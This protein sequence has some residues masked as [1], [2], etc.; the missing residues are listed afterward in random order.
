MTVAVLDFEANARFEWKPRLRTFGADLDR[1]MIAQ[2]E[3]AI[4]SVADDSGTR[5]RQWGSTTS[6]RLRDLRVRPRGRG[7]STA[8]KYSAAINRLALP[9]L[10]LAHTTKANADP[11]HPFGSVFWSNGARLTI[12]VAADGDERIVSTK[13]VNAR[14]PFPP[15]AF[16][17]AWTHELGPTEVP[18]ASSSR[19]RRRSLADRALAAVYTLGWKTVREITKVSSSRE[20]TFVISRVVIH[21][22]VY[23]AVR[24]RSAKVR[25]LA[26]DSTSTSGTSFGPSSCVHAHSRELRERRPRVDL[27]RQIVR[28]SRPCDADREAGAVQPEHAAERVLR[29]RRWPWSCGRAT[30]LGAP[31]C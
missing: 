29:V 23:G 7:V 3:T 2:P 6:Y 10:S 17:W 30:G 4:W 28:V 19:A 5:W 12:G 11:K 9:V 20:Q 26:P 24:A 21:P 25:A 13:K 8:T 18:E 16:D 31:A 15:F 1:V 14:A 22:R 27:L